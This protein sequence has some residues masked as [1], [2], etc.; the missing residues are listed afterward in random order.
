MQKFRSATVNKSFSTTPCGSSESEFPR[1]EAARETSGILGWIDWIQSVSSFDTAFMTR[2]GAKFGPA[3]GM[4]KGAR[5]TISGVN[6]K[7]TGVCSGAKVENAGRNRWR[8]HAP[9]EVDLSCCL[10]DFNMFS[11]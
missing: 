7:N 8:F 6:M 1:S 4:Q 2:I 10:M 11:G 3:S 9:R 5:C